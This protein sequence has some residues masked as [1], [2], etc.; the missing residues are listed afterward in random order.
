MGVETLP[1]PITSAL[2]SG[3]SDESTASLGRY[4]RPSMWNTV[5]KLAAAISIGPIA[6]TGRVFSIPALKSVFPGAVETKTGTGTILS[7]CAL[8]I[9]SVLLT[10]KNAARHRRVT[11]EH[12]RW[13]K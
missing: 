8:F 6:V 1:Q 7:A 4:C 5:P 10:A 3:S 11:R 12:S 2:G 13:P 9:T